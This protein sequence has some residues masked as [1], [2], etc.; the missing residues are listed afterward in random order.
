MQPTILAVFFEFSSTAF[1]MSAAGL[2]LLVIGLLAAKNDIIQARGIDKVVALTPLCFAIP[3]AAFGAEH[4]SGGIPLTMVPSYMPWR[5]FWIYF[6]GFALIAT[7]LS[8]ATKIQVRWS[9]LLLGTMM[10]LFVAMLHLPGAVRVGGRI[11]WTVVIRE[12][13]FG[14]GGW[15]LAGIATGGN[16]DGQRKSLIT[17][18]RVLIAIAAIVFG[19]QHFLHPLGLPGVPLQKQM[20]TWIPAR[21]FIDYLTGAFLIVAGVCFLLAR[22]TRMAATYLGMWIVLLVVAIY[23]PVLIGAL[24]DPS[25]GAK[26]EGLNYFADTLLFGG[27][28][29]SLARATTTRKSEGT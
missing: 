25:T 23:G 10:F 12:M 6:V 16:G 26:V 27:V 14:G 24:A 17:V 20:P 18:G 21:A 11:A 8:I 9:G 5:L 15:V 3:L 2:A 13:S 28:I 1:S 19:V 7:S 4:L 22:K 29:L